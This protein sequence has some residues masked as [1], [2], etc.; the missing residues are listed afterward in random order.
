MVLNMSSM[1][2]YIVCTWIGVPI[3][4]MYVSISAWAHYIALMDDGM[5]GVLRATHRRIKR[6]EVG[7]HSPCI[8]NMARMVI[9]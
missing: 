3:K 2:I 5:V 8:V 7:N 1:H 9:I 4:A 6:K